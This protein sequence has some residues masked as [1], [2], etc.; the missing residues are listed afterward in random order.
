MTETLLVFVSSVIS[1]METE[2]KAVRAAIDAIRLTRSWVF[3]FTTASSLPIP[4]SYL[5]VVRECDILVLLLGNRV[6]DPVKLEV[7]TAQGAKNPILA[8]LKQGAPEDVAEYARSVGATYAQYGTSDE[9]AE[10]VA[11]AIC[12]EIIRGWHD[13]YGIPSTDLGIV[14]E[15]LQRLR[16]WRP[17]PGH[18]RWVGVLRLNTS[19]VGRRIRCQQDGD[20]PTRRAAGRTVARV[21]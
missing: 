9:L 11:D 8:F 13:R 5:R 14:G 16:T 12:K 7:E 18:P 19:R 21:L 20:H 17:P 6:S 10:K 2:R 3:E 4:E 1:G 15:F